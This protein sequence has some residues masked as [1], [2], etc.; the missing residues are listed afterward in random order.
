[1]SNYF[2][3]GGYGVRFGWG[4]IEAAELSSPRGC[5]VVVDVLSFSTAV[6][7]AV[8]RGTRVYPYQWR[9]E[10]AEGYARAH[11]AA[12]AVGRSMT[13]ESVPWSLSPAVLRAAP[14]P[15]RLVLPS[16]KVLRSPNAPP[17]APWWPAACETPPR[18]ARGCRGR[19]S[20]PPP[21]R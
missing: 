10:T 3:Q 20:A 5:L 14:A 12:L 21:G 19:V 7:V 6:S 8:D 18:W 2:N 11:D 13:T 15:Q 16:P 1:M 9:D 17:V 4:P